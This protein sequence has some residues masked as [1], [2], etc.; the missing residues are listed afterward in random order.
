MHITPICNDSVTT[1][2]LW[3]KEKLLKVSKCY[4]FLWVQRRQNCSPAASFVNCVMTQY[5]LKVHLQTFLSIPVTQKFQILSCDTER[6]C[7]MQLLVLKIK[8]YRTI[9]FVLFCMGV[10][11]GI[12]H[13]GRKG[14]WGCFRTWCWGEYLDLKGQ[15]NG[16]MEEIA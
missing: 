9:I 1:K 5:L 15:G 4:N 12:W 14:S 2:N 11:I 8:T 6:Y 3:E 10:K 13:C 16:G 7:H